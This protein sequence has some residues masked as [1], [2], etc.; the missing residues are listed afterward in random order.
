MKN[1][2]IPTFK[3]M[4]DRYGDQLYQNIDIDDLTKTQLNEYFKYL[5]IC[6]RVEEKW[7]WMWKRNLS[8]WIYTYNNEKGMWQD[9]RT[10]EWFYDKVKHNDKTHTE[11][12]DL[13]D[14]LRRQIDRTLNRTFKEVYAATLNGSG[15]GNTSGKD[16]NS[17]TNTENGTNTGTESGKGRNFSFNYP[18]ANYQGGVIPYDLE[19]NPSIEFINV[20]NDAIN[21]NDTTNTTQSTQNTENEG[22]NSQNSEYTNKETNDHTNDQTSGDTGNETQTEGRTQKIANEYK[23]IYE[24]DGSNISDLATKMVELIRDT[25]FFKELCDHLMVCFNCIYTCD[26][27]D[28]ED[29]YYA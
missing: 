25:N 6:D 21:K 16:S 20:Q 5:R 12:T 27:L 29:F 7:I 4:V 11:S 3:E 23:D 15:T 9:Y 28:E 24:Y 13:T 14:D 1:S 10:N 19:N 17:Q 18:E 2:K 22:T 8:M 26:D